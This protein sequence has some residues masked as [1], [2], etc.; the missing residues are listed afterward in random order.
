MC[1]GFGQAVAT[2]TEWIWRGSPMTFAGKIALI[3]GASQGIGRVTALALGCEGATV[4]VNYK[5]NAEAAAQTA[6][7]VDAASGRGIPVQADLED[8]EAV[9]AMFRRIREEEAGALD[10]LVANAAATAFRPLMDVKPYHVDRTLHHH[11]QELPPAVPGG[12]VAHGRA[13]GQDRGRLRLGQLLLHPRP[14]VLGAAKAAM[15][16]LVRYLAIELAPHGINVNGVCSGPVE[17]DSA[18]IY[19]GP[20]WEEVRRTVAAATPRG[21]IATPDDVAR[22]IR[23]LCTDDADRLCGP[24]PGRQRGTRP[25][26]T[27]SSPGTRSATPSTSRCSTYATRRASWWAPRWSGASSGGGASSSLR[28][29]YRQSYDIFKLAGKL[30]VDNLIPPRDLRKEVA[31]YFE[32]FEHW[33]V[34]LPRRKH[35]TI[36]S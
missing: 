4:Y 25:P 35:A 29:A 3:T 14:R 32:L 11:G 16:S 10:M 19:T 34:Q 8:P 33:E 27:T 6:A 7:E 13:P 30:V 9:S 1:I 15:E 23:F 24:S 28:E 36:L 21:R 20:L 18:R 26:S 22:I 12:R 31:R 17:T 5:R 2:M